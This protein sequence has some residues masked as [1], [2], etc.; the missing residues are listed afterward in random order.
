MI[1]QFQLILKDMKKIGK[2][3]RQAEIIRGK[4]NRKRGKSESKNYSNM[5]RSYA[6]VESEKR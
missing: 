4:F 3:V 5:R 2:D 1:M 6:A